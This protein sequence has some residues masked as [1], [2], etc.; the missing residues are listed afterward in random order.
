MKKNRFYEVNKIN[1]QIVTNIAYKVSGFVLKK[2]DLISGCSIAT[3]ESRHNGVDP[4]QTNKG[5]GKGRKMLNE[6]PKRI[7]LIEKHNCNCNHLGLETPI[8]G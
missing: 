3:D 5:I 4:P 8:I 6:F 7:C 1:G 2:L